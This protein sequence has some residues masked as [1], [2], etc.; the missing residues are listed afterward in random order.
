MGRWAWARGGDCGS[1][2]P[3]SLDELAQLRTHTAWDRSASSSSPTLARIIFCSVVMVAARHKLPAVY[4]G[5][6]HD[7]GSTTAR[8]VDEIALIR[9]TINHYGARVHRIFVNSNSSRR[10]PEKIIAP[11]CP[12]QWLGPSA[13]QEIGTFSLKMK[14]SRVE[15]FNQ[16]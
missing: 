7:T 3:R 11:A 9:D 2:S 5:D 16:P 12:R 10:R 6:R 1:T 8:S 15:T 13:A 14:G 4:F